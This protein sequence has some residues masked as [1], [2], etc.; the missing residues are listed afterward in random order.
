MAVSDAWH[1]I[2][3]AGQL[4]RGWAC[5]EGCEVMYQPPYLP[6]LGLG[7]PHSRSSVWPQDRPHVLNPPYNALLACWC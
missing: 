2:G 5:A 4:S 3:A 6:E 1:R 7:E